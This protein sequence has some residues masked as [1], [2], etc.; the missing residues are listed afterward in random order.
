MGR[1]GLN[2]EVIINAAVDIIEANGYENFSMHALADKLGVKTA[3]LYSHIKSIDSLVTEVGC[4]ALNLHQQYLT[5]A[6]KDK[7]REDAVIALANAYRSFSKNHESLYRLIMQI[8]ISSNEKLKEL[9]GVITEPIMTV[10]EDYHISKEKKM[11]WQRVFRGM[12]HGFISQESYGYFSHFT[13]DVEDSYQISINCLVTGICKAEEA[14]CNG[15][16]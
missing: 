1:K 10:L 11:H 16:R 8:P 3:S 6:I 4:F 15:K 9:G 7:H 5:V 14:E 2:K 12:M 13:V